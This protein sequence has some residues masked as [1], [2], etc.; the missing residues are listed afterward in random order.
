MSFLKKSFIFILLP[1]ILISSFINLKAAQSAS[2]M[3]YVTNSFMS[4]RNY[5]AQNIAKHKKLAIGSALLIGSAVT[6]YAYKQYKQNVQELNKI[7][8]K[9]REIEEEK[10]NEKASTI[11]LSKE[12]IERLKTEPKKPFE[13]KF[14]VPEP[15]TKSYEYQVSTNVDPIKWELKAEIKFNNS[16]FTISAHPQLSYNLL[17]KD[18]LNWIMSHIGRF[19]HESRHLAWLDFYHNSSKDNTIS[20]RFIGLNTENKNPYKTVLTFCTSETREEFYKKY[21][22][23]WTQNTA[24][25]IRAAMKE[26]NPVILLYPEETITPYRVGNINNFIDR[27]IDKLSYEK[28]NFFSI[29]KRPMPSGKIPLEVLNKYSNEQSLEP[30]SDNS[31]E[32]TIKKRYRELVVKYHP[33]KSSLSKEDAEKATSEIQMA[34]EFATSQQKE[35]DAPIIPSEK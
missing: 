27:T 19:I 22:N 14:Y 26:L 20:Q 30:L 33:D 5:V 16:N 3:N 31:D 12:S 24:D 7:R 15:V 28:P 35:A 21:K 11:I 13:Q 18:V 34:Y 6:Y 8:D 25:G 1:F 2:W 17:N 29:I 10:L 4:L 32:Q 9:I 23:L